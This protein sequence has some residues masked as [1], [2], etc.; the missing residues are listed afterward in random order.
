MDVTRPI[1]S[2]IGSTSFCFLTTQE[3]RALSAKAI[4]NPVLLDTTGL[5]TAGGLY[6]PALGPMERSA[7]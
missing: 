6:D 3:I 4:V 5:P 2:S 1:T 7:M